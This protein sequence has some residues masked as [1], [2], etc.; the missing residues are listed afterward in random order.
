MPAEP[1]RA[2]RPFDTGL[3]P[4]EL[5]RAVTWGLKTNRA[6]TWGTTNMLISNSSL[7]E[8]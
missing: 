3:T 6:V 8:W 1:S 5:H 4:P 7:D 2:K